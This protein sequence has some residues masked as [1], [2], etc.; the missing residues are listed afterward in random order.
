MAFLMDKA[1]STAV[2]PDKEAL[3][4]ARQGAASAL[5]CVQTNPESKAP[6]MHQVGKTRAFPKTL[7]AFETIMVATV[8]G[9]AFGFTVLVFVISMVSST[10]AGTRDSGLYWATGQQ[11]VHHANPY[12]AGVL[13]RIEGAMGHLL[14]Y[15]GLMRNPPWAL[16]L[17]YPLGFAG[18][19]AATIAW[20]A[21]L[22][23]CLAGSVRMLWVL[24]G[25]PRN[26]RALLGYCFGPALIC[27]IMG[28]VSILAL[29]GL[30]LFLRLHRRRPFMAGIS[31][32]LCMLKPHLF[33]PF[34]AVLLA[35]IIVTRCYKLLAGAAAAMTASCLIAFLIDPMAWTQYARMM[36]S[37]GIATEFIPC[38]SD[39]LRLWAGRDV[40]WLRYLPA[41]LGCIW[42][43]AYFWPRRSTWDWTK[44][45]SLLMLVSILVAPYS[46]LYDQVLAIPALLRGA[47][48]TRSR[49]ILAALAF[50]S[51][52]IEVA[53]LGV[54]TL[55]PWTLWSAPAWLLWYLVARNSSEVK[56]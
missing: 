23:A 53:L 39:M 25:R 38:V 21:F 41:I 30:V 7:Y 33:L 34:G 49:R 54:S 43:L 19:Q 3:E 20:N 22:L 50:L 35:W 29:L 12:D 42:G 6:E 8:C 31:L 10:F 47:Y 40:L 46:W 27:L 45:G 5:Q 13:Q 24:H 16:P 37:S 9:L 36:H 1:P 17:V 28:Q 11:L 15:R 48:L 44:D 4:P 26:S 55:Y 56:L 52:L 32:W 2:E 14:Q 51:A 18:L